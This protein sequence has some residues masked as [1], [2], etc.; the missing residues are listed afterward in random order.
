MV[1]TAI[2]NS[3]ARS[4]G[5]SRR[6]RVKPSSDISEFLVNQLHTMWLGVDAGLCSCRCFHVADSSGTFTYLHSSRFILWRSRRSTPAGSSKSLGRLAEAVG[7]DS[8]WT[9]RLRLHSTC[10]PCLLWRLRV[11]H[12][13]SPRCGEILPPT[14]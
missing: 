12:A 11:L 2:K 14:L 1:Q 13:T 5:N 3:C 7:G 10:D 6:Q 9:T 8:P 4:Y